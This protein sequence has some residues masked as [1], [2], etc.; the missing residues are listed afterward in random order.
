MAVQPISVDRLVPFDPPS[1]KESLCSRADAKPCHLTAF[2]LKDW[3]LPEKCFKAITS[4]L[5]FMDRL[6]LECVNQSWRN[7][8]SYDEI[9]C[10]RVPD[11]TSWS[12]DKA[13]SRWSYR[14]SPIDK[15]W[16]TLEEFTLNQILNCVLSRCKNLVSLSFSPDCASNTDESADV[17]IVITAETVRLLKTHSPQLQ[18]LDLSQCAITDEALLKILKKN[19][20]TLVELNLSE[21]ILVPTGLLSS[22]HL[23][24]ALDDALCKMR[25]LRRLNP[26]A[27]EFDALRLPET[28]LQ[29]FKALELTNKTL[30][31]DE[32]LA[33][34]WSEGD[35]PNAY[36]L[37]SLVISDCN[38]IQRF[39][40][41]SHLQTLQRLTF[42][43]LPRLSD[44]DLQQIFHWCQKL[45]SVDLIDCRRVRFKFRWPPLLRRAR[46]IDPCQFDSQNLVCLGAQ[47]LKLRKFELRM[48]NLH[49]N[50][51]DP[52][53]FLAFAK[54]CSKL[55][56]VSID[57]ISVPNSIAFYFV[58][59]CKKLIRFSCSQVAMDAKLIGKIDPG[60]IID[61]KI[62]RLRSLQLSNMNLNFHG[63]ME[64]LDHCHNLRML[65]LRRISFD[66]GSTDT[67][68]AFLSLLAKRCLKLENLAI[69]DCTNL[70]PQAIESYM[71]KRQQQLQ[72][73]KAAIVKRLEFSYRNS[74]SKLMS[75]EEAVTARMKSLGVDFDQESGVDYSL[76]KGTSFGFALDQ[77]A[78]C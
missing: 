62:L 65:S 56:S 58:I 28:G 33:R 37:E 46:I 27:H 50:G 42:Q 60:D 19:K 16:S 64:M 69:M 18:S 41:I 38:S 3:E 54:V 14:S 53:A 22:C 71:D 66:C 63:F 15:E 13:L 24:R 51:P 17:K 40:I 61:R 74:F 32:Q 47:C 72:G 59:Y 70:L 57:V 29:S 23:E 78:F 26:S 7:S 11:L 77:P 45:T 12:S 73:N 68:S 30:L 20:R 52:N 6:V 21:C 67:F 35:R 2:S 75:N 25:R 39:D 43:R 44:E 5:D 36:Q 8:I 76:H 1:F 10:F 9:K 4:R 31:G 34:L 49:T 48:K 55:R